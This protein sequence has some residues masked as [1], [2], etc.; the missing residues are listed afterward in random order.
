MNV[1]NPY[2][3][4]GETQETPRNWLKGGGM[5]NQSWTSKI[6]IS[7]ATGPGME[8]RTPISCDKKHDFHDEDL[9]AHYDPLHAPSHSISGTTS[10]H[11]CGW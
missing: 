9:Q 7:W 6:G 11:L 2:W 3:Q 5:E 8:S 1:A 4:P 10:V